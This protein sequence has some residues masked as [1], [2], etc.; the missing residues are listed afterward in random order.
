MNSG[1]PTKA[2]RHYFSSGGGGGG[3]NEVETAKTIV[4]VK[5]SKPTDEVRG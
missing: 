4:A 3:E 1:E 5:F 2:R